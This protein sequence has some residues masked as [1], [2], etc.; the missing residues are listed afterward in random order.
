MRGGRQL[1]KPDVARPLDGRVSPQFGGC[2]AEKGRLLSWTHVWRTSCLRR[3]RLAK[4]RS[5]SCIRIQPHCSSFQEWTIF[6]ASVMPLTRLFSCETHGDFRRPLQEYTAVH[7]ANAAGE[8]ESDGLRRAADRMPTAAVST[9]T[10][11]TPP[12]SA[13]LSLDDEGS[14]LDGLPHFAW[15][16]TFDMRGGRKQAKLACGRPPRWKG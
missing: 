9:A 10:A 4:R 11:P 3:Q 8:I 5:C 12:P 2:T 13:A 7:I 15:G 14:W 1:A 16:L 6:A